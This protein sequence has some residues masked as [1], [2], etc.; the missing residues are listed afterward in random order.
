VERPELHHRGRPGGAQQQV[1]DLRFE[2]VELGRHGLR[3][4][5]GVLPLSLP[6]RSELACE[7]FV[8]LEDVPQ[9]DQPQLTVLHVDLSCRK[10]SGHSIE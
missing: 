2:V 4:R 6:D 5:L 1:G 7:L 9:V 10:T 3:H 8:E